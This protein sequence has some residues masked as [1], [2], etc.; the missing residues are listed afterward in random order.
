MAALSGVLADWGDRATSAPA[1]VLAIISG[2]VSTLPRLLVG[3]AVAAVH[4]AGDALTQWSHT[5]PAPR[6]YFY[7]YINL[8]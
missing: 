8:V 6:N 5:G 2:T 7:F 3:D 1:G 4:I